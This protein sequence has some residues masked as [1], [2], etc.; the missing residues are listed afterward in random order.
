[1]TE[2]LHIIGA[3]IGRTGTNSLKLALEQLL[4]RPCYH[5]FEAEA[6]QHF[7]TWRLAAEGQPPDWTAFL[8]DYSATVDGPACHFWE[9]LAA[10]FPNAKI[11]LSIRETDDWYRS[12]SQTIIEGTRKAP[13]GP[14]VEMEKAIAR[15]SG[16][17]LLAGS[18]SDI[19]DAYDRHNTH[20]L[21]TVPPD[22]LI[23]WRPGDG[24][25]PI[26]RALSLEIPDTPFPHVNSTEDF[27]RTR[28]R[29]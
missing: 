6:Q 19:R 27:R 4:G 18:E 21:Q 12:A 8:Q 1:M 16:M 7:E 14:F 26:C 17:D 15:L 25:E 29:T 24:W 3:G 20:V 2:G 28:I 9:P 11:L 22:R 10:L 23:A 5:M 13:P